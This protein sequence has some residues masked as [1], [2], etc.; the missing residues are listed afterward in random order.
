MAVAFI[1]FGVSPG[2]TSTSCVIV[3]P[4][5]LAVGNLMI[6]H[7]SS[8]S[9][10]AITAPDVSW[11]Q[12]QNLPTSN[13]RGAAF[14]KQATSTDVAA[15]SFTFTCGNADN[16]GAISTWS[17]HDRNIPI[18]TSNG[19]ASTTTTSTVTSPTITPRPQLPAAGSP[20]APAASR[21]IK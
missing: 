21:L 4:T 13:G 14:Y 19:Q 3:K 9:P 12:L 18:A 7:I 15:A 6:A 2:A 16:K 11:T 17:G 10:T 8:A 1:E 20:S 5:N